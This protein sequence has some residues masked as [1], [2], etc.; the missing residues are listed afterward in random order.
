MIQFKQFPA[1]V[2]ICATL[3]LGISLADDD[4]RKTR[5]SEKDTTVGRTETNRQNRV[6]T[7]RDTR[8]SGQNRSTK[9]EDDS[10]NASTGGSQGGSSGQ[11]GGGSQCLGCHSSVPTGTPPHPIPPNGQPSGQNGNTG[12][13]SGGGSANNGN[14]GG[15]NGSGTTP[16][17]S[18]YKVLGWNNL[19]MHCMDADFSIFSLLPP[20]NTIHA[21]VISPQGLL[22]TQPPDL[23]VTYEAVSD[24]H[25]SINKTSAGKTNFWD[26]TD[27][28]FGVTLPVDVGLPVP[29]PNSFSMPGASNTPQLM[30]FDN[31]L[32]WF[33]AYGIPITP[34]DDFGRYNMYPLMRLTVKS[35][36]GTVAS[37]DI[38]LP[39]SDE[40]DCS[41]CH[42]SG[43]GP[44]AEPIAGWVN[45]PD[46]QRDFRLNILRL[47]DDRELPNPL[48]KQA[49]AAGGFNPGGLTSSVVTDGAP[50]LCARCHLSE[51]LPNSGMPGIKP[52]TQVIH[53]LHAT[54]TD[55]LTNVPLGASDNRSACYRCHPGSDTRCLRGAMGK[56]VA[57]DGSML[58]QCQ[59]CHGSMHEVGAANRTGWLDEPTCQSCH[60]GTALSNNGQIRYTS[61]F[62]TD[63][64]TRQAVDATFATNT[65]APSAG[66]SLYRFSKGHGGL[67]CS[68]CHGSTH[69]EFPSMEENDNIYSTKLQGHDGP[70]GECQ[71]CH[72][73][74]PSG[75]GPH[76]LHPVGQ[77]W[78]QGH[79]EGGG[80]SASMAN[81]GSTSSTNSGQI[82]S[83]QCSTCHGTTPSS[84][85]PH[86]IPMTINRPAQAQANTGVPASVSQAAQQ[87]AQLITPSISSSQGGGTSNCQACHGLDYRGTVLSRAMTDRT[88]DAGDFGTKTFAKGHQFS[89]YD[90]HNGPGG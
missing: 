33:A 55:P 3:I 17:I 57:Q 79:H 35:G 47:H 38:V 63:G 16:V 87:A 12:S 27:A 71:A 6:A 56:A 20:Y 4:H 26:Y 36:T 19:G 77:Q 90:C 15:S 13:G 14:N 69:A 8:R 64:Q 32:G 54:V 65:D 18:S 83:S 75:G 53:S 31:D 78:V 67:Y 51:A 7:Q 88:L 89:C 85:P 23:T 82:T 2:I 44:A 80:G 72:A 86:P 25:G 24:P 21:Q 39:V 10:E 70:L 11:A 9:A 5:K 52:L 28:F 73:S 49:L 74:V 68:A 34:I 45:D 61:V 46:P 22:L 50:I 76:G 41:A 66:L 62:E 43:T 29:G 59:S 81:T 1:A 84:S 40:M 48:F 42:A 60:T 37:S 58:M 30:E